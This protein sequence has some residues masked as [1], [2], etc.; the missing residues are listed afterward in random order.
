M[1]GA[2]SK[3][4]THVKPYLEEINAKVRQGVIEEEIA[5]AL[6]IS[7]ATLNNYKKQHKEFAEAL[8]KDKG[9]DVLQQL[10]NAGV[11]SATGYFEEEETTTIVLVGEENEI[12]KKQK[13]INKR[14][15][16]PNPTLN[17]YYTKHFGKDEGFTTDPLKHEL[18]KAKFDFEK[19][20]ASLKDLTDYD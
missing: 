16:P 10:I 8:S 12:G 14:Y 13:V 3:Y 2:K 6:N 7:V 20:R 9:K 1:A 5:K 15:Y 19:A 18:E 17:I 4:E 11:R